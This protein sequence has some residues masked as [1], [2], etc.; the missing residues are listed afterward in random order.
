MIGRMEEYEEA[1]YRD[2]N[3]LIKWFFGDEY[4]GTY[5]IN[6]LSWNTAQFVVNYTDIE[7]KKVEV[8]YFSIYLWEEY[9]EEVF[10]EDE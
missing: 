7:Q 2:I 9:F 8:S 6:V 5:V 4:I 3:K 10:Y 1:A